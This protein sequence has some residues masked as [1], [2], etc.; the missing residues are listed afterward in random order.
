MVDVS[1]KAPTSRSATAVG[2]VV[3]NS[4]AFDILLSSESGSSGDSSPSGK[5]NIKGDALSVARLAGIMAAKQTSSLIPLCHPIPLSHV[6]VD[7][8]LDHDT[9]SVKVEA[10]AKCEDSRTGVEMEALTAASVACLT[11]WDMLKSVSGKEMEIK[12]LKVVQKS[13]GKSGDWHRE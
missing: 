6:H 8:S 7:L 5:K 4:A 13:G 9:R 10:R 12:D 1:P 2:R 11:V 3:V